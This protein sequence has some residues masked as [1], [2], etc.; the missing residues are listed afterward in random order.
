MLEDEVGSDSKILKEGEK[1]VE[2]VV[3]RAEEA[4]AHF[5]MATGQPEGHTVSDF[6]KD[7]IHT[8]KETIG[9]AGTETEAK[10]K[11][12][13]KNVDDRVDADRGA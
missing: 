5:G 2:N 12:K 7:S 4:G 3:R 8:V 1:M 10:I 6:V 11:S 13:V 9:L